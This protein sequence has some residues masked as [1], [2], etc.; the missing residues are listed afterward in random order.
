MGSVYT[1]GG[2]LKIEVRNYLQ[3]KSK[4]DADFRIVC[5]LLEESKVQESTIQ[6]YSRDLT[7]A[8]IEFFEQKDGFM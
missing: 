1:L 6:R 5:P 2:L 3:T 4:Y 8:D 7:D